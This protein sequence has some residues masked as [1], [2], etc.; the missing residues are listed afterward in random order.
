MLAKFVPSDAQ[1][2]LEFDLMQCD[3]INQYFAHLK[4]DNT[5]LVPDAFV[6][7]GLTSKPFGFKVKD[8]NGDKTDA[9]EKVRQ[10]LDQLPFSLKNNRNNYVQ[11]R[12]HLVNHHSSYLVDQHSSE[13]DSEV[14]LHEFMLDDDVKDYVRLNFK[15]APWVIVNLYNADRKNLTVDIASFLEARDACQGVYDALYADYCQLR[16]DVTHSF[17]KPDLDLSNLSLDGNNNE[18]D[19]ADDGA[20]GETEQNPDADHD[21][22]AKNE[23]DSDADD[24]SN[25]DPDSK[26]NTDS[27]D[28]NSDDEQNSDNSVDASDSSENESD[29]ETELDSD[30]DHDSLAKN[31]EDSDAD[32][33]SNLDPDNKQD[34]NGNDDNSDDEQDSDNSVDGSDSGEN[35]S[36]SETEQGSDAGD[37]PINKAASTDNLTDDQS[38]S[39]D[40]GT[41]DPESGKVEAESN[42]ADDENSNSESESNSTVSGDTLSKPS[43]S[44]TDDKPHVGTTDETTDQNNNSLAD[45][46]QS[47]SSENQSTTSESSSTSAGESS[48]QSSQPKDPVPTVP[49]LRDITNEG[50]NDERELYRTL[51]TALKRIDDKKTQP[52][53]SKEQEDFYRKL[54]ERLDKVGDVHN[55]SNVQLETRLQEKLLSAIDRFLATTEEQREKDR[56]AREAA[57]RQAKEEALLKKEEESAKKEAGKTERQK[58]T[59]DQDKMIANL[60]NENLS[61]E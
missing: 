48:V 28:D 1:N 55:S 12:Y 16:E 46:G 17:M 61:A 3:N 24:E 56:L 21:S 26:Q 31:E 35:E 57:E 33:N 7:G 32:D 6:I 8:T 5:K 13:F 54:V 18:I 49:V 15:V 43:G 4:D 36:D 52:A 50:N 42:S 37:E 22:L 47:A 60:L 9:F 40:S 45:D 20:V 58:F 29:S 34:T 2:K 23:K 11:I 27:N 10:V 41:N 30:A 14:D 53:R 25:F 19:D 44:E 39:K 51:I 38:E 59:D